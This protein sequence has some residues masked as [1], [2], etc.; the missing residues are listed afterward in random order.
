MRCLLIIRNIIFLKKSSRKL[1]I[2]YIIRTYLR[3]I[4]EIGVILKRII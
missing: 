3:N 1:K 4:V 2:R